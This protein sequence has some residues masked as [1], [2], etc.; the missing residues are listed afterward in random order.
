MNIRTS[1]DISERLT[2]RQIEVLALVARR[3]SSKE[4][5]RQLNV[6]HKTIDRHVEEINERLGVSTRSEAA[7]LYIEAQAHR[8]E[9]LPMGVA[10]LAP[11]FTIPAVIGQPGQQ[12][13][14]VEIGSEHIVSTLLTVIIRLIKLPPLGGGKTNALNQAER[15]VAIGRIAFVSIIFV[16]A[17]VAVI[18]G[19]L[20][21]LH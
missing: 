20:Q 5:G 11:S 18:S 12:S 19:I 2:P 16:A 21:L 4:I 17:V 10:T 14:G 8:G 15:M 6:S 7:R 1:V 13:D 3:F 9:Q